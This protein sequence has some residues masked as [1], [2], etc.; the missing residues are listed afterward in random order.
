[1]VKSIFLQ[2]GDEIFVDD[3][4]YER[5]N[6]HIWHKVSWGFGRIGIR[7]NVNGNTSVHLPTFI[8]NKTATQINRGMDFTKKN[9]TTENI[10]IYKPA[11][12]NSVSQYKGVSKTGKKW[13]ARIRYKQK[14]IHLGTFS[15]E[16]EAAEAYNDAVDEFYEGKGFKNVIGKDNRRIKNDFHSDKKFPIGRYDENKSTFKGVWMYKDK[17]LSGIWLNGDSHYVGTFESEKKAALAYNKCALYIHGE[18]AFLNDVPITDELKDFIS[19]W[20]I[21]EKIKKLKED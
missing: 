16:E 10:Q 2:D 6:K 11:E 13:R 8:V 7:G 12:F 5:V 15:T 4:D 19:N 20:E 18:R 14:E 3:E 1:M 17:I 21:P 9:I